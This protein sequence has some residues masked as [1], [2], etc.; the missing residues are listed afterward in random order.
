MT[1]EPVCLEAG[2]AV[3][4]CE[5]LGFLGQWLASDRPGLGDS[6]QRFV[7]SGAYDVEALQAGV[8]RFEFLLGG[9]GESLFR[10]DEP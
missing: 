3:E 8:L 5:L 2:D 6:L 1:V 9:S 10:G 4:L 7:G